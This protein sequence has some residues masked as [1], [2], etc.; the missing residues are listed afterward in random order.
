MVSWRWEEDGCTSIAG[1]L[2]SWYKRAVRI[3][4][5]KLFSALPS[6]SSVRQ[7]ASGEED[8]ARIY[9]DLMHMIIRRARG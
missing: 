9:L 7:Y 2:G 3:L 6:E 8:L 1:V 5:K 4:M